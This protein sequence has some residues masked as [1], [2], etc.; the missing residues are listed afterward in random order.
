MTNPFVNDPFAILY[1]AFT[2]FCPDKKCKISWEYDLTDEYGDKVYGT[3][4]F[5]DDQFYIYI[6]CEI[7]VNDAVEIFCHELA[8]VMAGIDF[9]HG[10]AWEDA[11]NKLQNKYDEIGNQLFGDN[12]EN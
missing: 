12:Y 3:T 4:V 1:S 2:S 9:A 6:N 11:Y 10:E 5:S 7:P 8:H